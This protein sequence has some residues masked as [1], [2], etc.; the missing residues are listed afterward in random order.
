MVGQIVNHILKAMLRYSNLRT[1]VAFM[2]WP[3]PIGR[4]VKKATTT[5]VH[6]VSQIRV[7]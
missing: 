6:T 7:H 1:M 4:T 5:V 3:T 2:V